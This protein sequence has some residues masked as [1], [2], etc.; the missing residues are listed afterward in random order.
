MSE[1]YTN[2]QLGDMIKDGFK[3]VHKRQDTSNG[4]L[5]KLELWKA[6]MHG[7]WVVLACI[8]VPLAIVVM[9]PRVDAYF[10]GPIDLELQAAI[11]ARI[12][13]YLIIN[14]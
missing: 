5:K 14:E 1:S 10:N 11:D 9:G 7:M 3:A 4:R 2:R 12:N 8:V 6:T 13:K